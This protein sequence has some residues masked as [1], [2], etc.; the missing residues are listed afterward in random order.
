MAVLVLREDLANELQGRFFAAADGFRSKR[1]A[2]TVR[3]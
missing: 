3:Q 1:A 2:S